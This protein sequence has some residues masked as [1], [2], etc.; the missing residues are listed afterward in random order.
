M[1][2]HVEGMHCMHCAG[3]VEKAMMELGAKSA[4]VDLEKKIC[5]VEGLSDQE[6]IRNAVAQKGFQ[7]VA[8]DA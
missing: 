1:T 3:K 4:K 7:V 6:A 8:I 5:Q 2:V